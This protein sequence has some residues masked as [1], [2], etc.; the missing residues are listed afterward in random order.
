MIFLGSKLY[1]GVYE[2]SGR[3]P[4]GILHLEGQAKK[5]H[6]I[7]RDDKSYEDEK[8]S[9]WGE[10]TEQV[11]LSFLGRKVPLVKCHHFSLQRLHVCAGD[12]FLMGC[13]VT[14]NLPL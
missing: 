11:P 8:L 5:E 1:V 6:G 13:N 12:S 10:N 7:I 14:S 4:Q 2:S 3:G 9:R